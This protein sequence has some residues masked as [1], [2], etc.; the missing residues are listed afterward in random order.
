MPPVATWFR[1][2]D[3]VAAFLRG[4]PLSGGPRWRA[5]PVGASGQPAFGHYIWDNAKGRFMPHGINVLTLSGARICEITAFLTPAAFARF[6]LPD[7]P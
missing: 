1:G 5:L 4:W 7:R 3:A 2:R 6:G